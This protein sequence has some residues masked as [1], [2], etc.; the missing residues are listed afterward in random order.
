MFSDLFDKYPLSFF[1]FLSFLLIIFLFSFPMFCYMDYTLHFCYSVSWSVYMVDNLYD[2][3]S[4]HAPLPKNSSHTSVGE[5]LA[6]VFVQYDPRTL[7]WHEWT[8]GRR[9]TLTGLIKISP[10]G[11]WNWDLTCTSPFG[12]L[13]RSKK[14]CK[15]ELCFHVCTIHSGNWGEGTKWKRGANIC[16]CMHSKAR[17][18]KGRERVGQQGEGEACLSPQVTCSPLVPESHLPWPCAR[19]ALV[20]GRHPSH[21]VGGPTWCWLLTMSH[22]KVA[23]FSQRW[24]GATS[25]RTHHCRLTDPPPG[26]LVLWCPHPLRSSLLKS[27]HL[28]WGRVIPLRR[29]LFFSHTPGPH[30]IVGHLCLPQ[31]KGCIWGGGPWSFSH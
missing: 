1:F 30:L 28:A 31:G 12:V 18:G 4:G 20:A 2:F 9:L 13:T 21:I 22:F 26:L 10:L 15:L 7:A 23:V 16:K 6:T 19:P 5:P 25:K 3:F 17:K 14:I 8:K 24:H 29:W 11:I 27:H